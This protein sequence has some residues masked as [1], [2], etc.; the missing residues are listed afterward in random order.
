V[1]YVKGR[2]DVLHQNRHNFGTTTAEE[3]IERLRALL[4]ATLANRQAF[5]EA[6]HEEI[7]ACDLDVA[8][9][10][11]MIKG[12]IDFAAKHLKRWMKPKRV[13]NS[14]ATMGKKCYVLPE[15]KGVVL[16]LST[17]NA[18]VCI[19]LLPVVAALSAGNTVA[20]KPSEL[21]PHSSTVLRNM[22]EG[23]LP[24]DEAAVFEGDA[25]V[26]TALLDQPFNHIYYTGGQRVGRIVM[27]AAAE[28]FASVTLEMGGKNP[29]IIDASA[30][31]ENAATKTGWGRLSNAGQVCVAPDYALVHASCMDAFMQ[32]LRSSI[33]R[34]YDS[35]GK[36]FKQSREVL[37]LINEE[38]FA[39]VAGLLEDATEKGATV[40][41]GG[42]MD[43][44]E[45][46]VAPTILTGVSEEMRIMREE[47]FGP[48]I[49]IVPFE[50]REEAVEIIRRRSK[51]LAVYI[52]ARERAAVDYF[53]S[54]TSAGSTV[55]NHNLIQ[56]GTNPRLPFGGINQSGM[57][58]IGGHRGFIEMS[59]ER[60]VVE[61][62]L[63]WLDINP[64]FPPY[65]NTYRKMIE[66]ALS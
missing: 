10:I 19:G 59:N 5:A 52:H 63:G 40:M 64:N 55:V 50:T 41:M 24:E 12:E 4:A 39:H 45:R 20:L 53:L 27:K 51:P 6:A 18:P 3:R 2:F 26:A 13:R 23:T 16:N 11:M 33:T 7:R 35:A 28:N 22:I 21:A 54:N 48:I 37:R 58:R 15:P 1:D 36:G 30:D 44:E 66:K 61:A 49:A 29:A 17:W 34:M 31:I 32:N 43:A 14:Q 38:Q 46:Y 60:S 9:Q 65:S 8:A 47:V 25:T 56:S 57:G 62:R 42:D